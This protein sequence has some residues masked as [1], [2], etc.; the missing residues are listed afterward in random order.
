VNENNEEKD[1]NLDELIGDK[2]DHEKSQNQDE[3]E[4][5]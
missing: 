4:N 5:N 1:E 2:S 3:D